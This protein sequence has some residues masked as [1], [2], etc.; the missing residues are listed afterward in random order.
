MSPFKMVLEQKCQ[1]CSYET[2]PK[3]SLWF[4]TVHK[5]LVK[6]N[7]TIYKVVFLVGLIRRPERDLVSI[8]VTSAG[9]LIFPTLGLFFGVAAFWL[10]L[11]GGDFAKVVGV[12]ADGLTGS[13]TSGIAEVASSSDR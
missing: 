5:C 10:L 1:K 7:R 12:S 3:K 9:V 2:E 4:Q 8:G 6:L 13:C 11:A